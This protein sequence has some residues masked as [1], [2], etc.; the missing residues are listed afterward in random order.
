MRSAVRTGVSGFVA[1]ASLVSLLIAWR[2]GRIGEPIAE[3][4]ERGEKLWHASC[5]AQEFDGACL[6]LA[7]APTAPQ[8]GPASTRHWIVVPRDAA[9]QAA[10]LAIFAGV[11][12]RLAPSL[13]E[14]RYALGLARLYEGDALRE[15]ALATPFPHELDEQQLGPW[16]ATRTATAARADAKY[17]EVLGGG[18]PTTMIAALERSGHVAEDVANQLFTIEIPSWVRTG[19]L[20]ADKVDAYCDAM[21][22]AA[23]PALRVAI[24]MY[25]ACFAKAS[26]L[27]RV[28]ESSAS[29]ETA[30]ERL[31]PEQYPTLGELQSVQPGDVWIDAGRAALRCRKF[32]LAKQLFAVAP[33]SYDAIIGLG[34]AQRGLRDLDG[35]QA[36]YERARDSDPN[37]DEAYYDLGILDKDFRATTTTD[38]DPAVAL[39]RS[40][41]TYEHA[42]ALFAQF[43]LETG[44]ALERQE[45]QEWMADCD[46]AM[47]QIDAFLDQR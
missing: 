23:E 6:A 8:C 18:E 22:S 12:D 24:D 37:R 32:E 15:A 17:A 29:C 26:E 45:A 10:A 31:E 20:A 28:S 2:H 36:S 3:S 25:V 4:L 38:P 34:I 35:A 9:K 41:D 33:T 21:T 30:L 42:R 39:R 16:L 27:G 14:D 1:A 44:R 5:P 7:P 43:L 11:I 13:T 47:A 40:R 19:P 46:K